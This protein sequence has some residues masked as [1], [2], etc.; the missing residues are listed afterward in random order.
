M[1]EISHDHNF[2]NLLLDFPLESLEFFFPKALKEWGEVQKISFCRQ[3]P[4]KHHL[5]NAS[6]ELDMPVLFH[7]K[8]KTLL[9]WLV[10][11]QEEKKL[12]SI[13]KLMRYT[14]DLMETY[15]N[16]VVVPTVLFTD[17][18]K[19]RTNVLRQLESRMGN[20]VFVHFEYKYCKLFDFNARD[21]YETN[22][23]VV[24]ILLPKMNYEPSERKKVIRQAYLGLYQLASIALFEKYIYFI[25]TY[26]QMAQ[27]EQV[28]LYQEFITKKET[29]M[30]A[31][32]IKDI[33]HKEGR[34]EGQQKS[35]FS[36]VR[37]ARKQGISE[38]VIAQIANLDIVSVNKILNN[39]PIDI[40]LHLLDGKS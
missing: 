22:N 1:T 28:S 29:A 20:K 8:E 5:S 34:K 11:F 3:E 7:F 16:A 19:W 17:R 14:T 23:P 30:L 27:E 31:Q 21:Y 15:P 18:K 2:K 24:K 40:P 6:L 4:K 38:A 35:V 9:L 13:H 37:N 33:G 32:Y 25:D 26:A 12:F 10:E 36:M 39:E